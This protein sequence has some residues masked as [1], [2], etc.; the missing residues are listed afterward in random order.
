V[1]F[2]KIRAKQRA[3]MSNIKHG[4]ANTKLFYLRANGRKRK[5]HIQ[6]HQTLEGLAMSHEDKEKEIEQHFNLL[7]GTKQ[8]RSLA[9]NWGDLNY[10]SFDLA[11]LD[12]DLQEEEV[13]QAISDMKKDNA[14]GPDEFIRGFYSKCWE[15]VRV[16]VVQA[17]KQ[18]SQLGDHT[19]NLLN[20]ANIVLLPK[21]EQALSV[22]DYK[23]IS[24]VHNIA[25]VFSKILANML[26][27]H[28]PSMVSLSQSAFIKRRC[29]HD[30]FTLVQSLVKELHRKKILAIFI[31]LDITKAFD[32]VSWAYLLDLMEHL[33][34]G[35]KWREWISIALATSSSRIL[36]NGVPGTPIKHERGLRQ[37]DPLLP[38]LFILEMDPY[39]K[40]YSLQLRGTFFIQSPLDRWASK[41]RYTL[42]MQHYSSTLV[43]RTS[44]A[45]KRF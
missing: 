3:T 31:K 8:R 27:P 29:I 4:D 37:G 15:I 28:L 9:I 18:L 21:K 2:E 24:L 5:K 6:A 12:I 17:I 44:S 14:P 11:D 25:K 20:S 41:H 39:K 1:A 22:G 23:P 16:D 34:F 42:M 45:S 26:A 38:M 19:F 7:L 35:P 13:R 30:N 36:L 43:M 32:S 33:G 10:P 40:S